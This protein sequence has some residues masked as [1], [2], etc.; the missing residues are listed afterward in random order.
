[1]S[2]LPRNPSNQEQFN[3]NVIESPIQLV[4]FA[5]SA[6]GELIKSITA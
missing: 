2:P 6:V 1:M 3:I 5:L 4:A